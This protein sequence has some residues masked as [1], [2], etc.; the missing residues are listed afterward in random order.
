MKLNLLKSSAKIKTIFKK[1]IKY[2]KAINKTFN[3]LENN[4]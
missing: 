1:E 3:W 2:Q 4:D